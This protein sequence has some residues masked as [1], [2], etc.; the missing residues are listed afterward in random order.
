MR[1]QIVQEQSALDLPLPTHATPGS[2][3][4]DLYAN[5]TD[6]IILQPGERA[7][8]SAGISIAVPEGF[9]AQVRPRSGLARKFG[10]SMVNTPGTIDCDYRGVVHVLLINLGSEPFTVNRGDRIAQM[11]VCPVTRVEWDI[12]TTLSETIRGVGG[13]GHTGR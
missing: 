4:V 13:F 11:V 6:P 3:G 12:Q 2:A 5:V 9:E 1:I 8:V 7:A 10:I